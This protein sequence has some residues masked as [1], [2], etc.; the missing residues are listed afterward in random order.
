MGFFFDTVV[1]PFLFG[2]IGVL[3][4]HLGVRLTKAASL[5]VQFGDANEDLV[6]KMQELVRA[7]NEVLLLELDITELVEKAGPLE[8][9][10][11][12]QR[13]R[14]LAHA[15]PPMVLQQVRR[16]N[17][18]EPPP[19][20]PEQEPAPVVVDVG[21]PQLRSVAGGWTGRKR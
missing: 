10:R 20:P 21:E 12:I 17:L 9:A 2:G 19:E 15:L 8:R 14:E 6:V 1:L 16:W 18:A 5:R 7:K 11:W 4:F 13:M 3:I